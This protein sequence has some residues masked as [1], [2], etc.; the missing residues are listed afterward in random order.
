MHVRQV[1]PPITR[2]LGSYQRMR[3][4]WYQTRFVH[5]GNFSWEKSLPKGRQHRGFTCRSNSGML[6]GVPGI[7]CSNSPLSLSLSLCG[8]MPK[9]MMLVDFS[10]VKDVKRMCELDTSLRLGY[11]DGNRANDPRRLYFLF[12]HNKV[13]IG[14]RREGDDATIK[15]P[16]RI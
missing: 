5:V 9:Y 4:W 3:H 11:D 12:A 7:L 1:L 10:Q 15:L 6:I 8:L 13:P 16:E 14:T 2:V